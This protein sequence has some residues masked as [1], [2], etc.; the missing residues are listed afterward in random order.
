MF[1]NCLIC[2][3]FTDGL[4]RII[5]FVSSLKEGGFQQ[6]TFLHS[7]PLWEEGEIPR[8]D[9]E[10]MAEAK[11]KL[12]PASEN[13]PEGMKVNIEVLS[14]NAAD[15]ILATVKKYEIDFIITGTPL[16]SS[17]QNLLFGSTTAKLTK[18]LN[19]PMMVL[20]PQLVSVYR[21][22]EIALRLSS[23]NDYWLIPYQNHEHD[24]DLLTKIKTCAIGK[25]SCNPPKCLLITVVED[26]SR[27]KILMENHLHEAQTKL[28]KYKEDLESAG[29]E[30]ETIVKTGN[31]L[32]EIFETA[33]TS[34]IS[35][36]AVANDREGNVI[37][38]ILNLTVGNDSNNM[39]NCSWFPLIYFPLK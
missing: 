8:V 26:V 25:G 39:L 27:S 28:A 15:N 21:E 20:R 30:V 2:T 31:R 9:K 24:R 16:S 14:G 36:I 17:W 38:R 13:I 19:V 22:E 12:A 29:V 1:K 23:L 10:R 4:Q 34:N 33:F 3:D 18:R 7:V 32:E 37:D 5:H 35:A 11:E 6:V